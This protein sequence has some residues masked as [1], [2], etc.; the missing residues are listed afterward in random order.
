MGIF[1]GIIGF[2]LGVFV[3]GLWAR[4]SPTTFNSAVVNARTATDVEIAAI[5][6][7]L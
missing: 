1:E 6:A 4:Y 2:A 5:K 7:K 3:T